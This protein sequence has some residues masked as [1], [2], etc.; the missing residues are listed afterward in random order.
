V[1]KLLL[2]A[3]LI[4]SLFAREKGGLESKGS[5]YSDL[6]LLHYVNSD[7]SDSL[8]FSGMSTLSLDVKNRNRRHAK[9]NCAFEIKMPYGDGLENFPLPGEDGSEDI[10]LSD[11]VIASYDRSVLLLDLRR[12]YAALYFN[13]FELS[14]GRQYIGFGQGMIFSPIDL[15][16]T[17]DVSDFRYRKNGADVINGEFAFTNLSGVSLTA[18]LPYG[19]REHTTALKLF[20]TLG[21]FDLAVVGMYRHLNEKGLTGFSFK[22]DAFVGFY[23]EG[24]VHL[25]NKTDTLSF[26]GMVGID[27]SIVSKWFFV[28]E[29][30]YTGYNNDHWM[31]LAANYSINEL[32]AAGAS[33]IHSIGAKSSLATAQI[34]YNVLQNADLTAFIRGYNSE[35][36]TEGMPLYDIDYSIRVV[37][38]F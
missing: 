34:T 30:Q 4:S 15:F 27:Y 2:I 33:V 20:G 32:L 8:G 18:E 3:I 36:S 23:G 5:F 12:L 37:V 26:D 38:K 22:G 28:G 31:F 14:V 9:V 29:Y 21:S 16:S 6:S 19:D 35:V 7:E 25:P 13:K 11:F 17:V 1:K 10:P 24:L